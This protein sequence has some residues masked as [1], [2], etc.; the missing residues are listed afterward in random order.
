MQHIAWRYLVTNQARP[1]A[2][3]SF[4]SF[5]LGLC[6][7][8]YVCLY[9]CLYLCLYLGLCLCLYLCYSNAPNS[10]A[11]RYLVTNQALYTFIC[12]NHFQTPI[13]LSLCIC[14]PIHLYLC[15]SVNMHPCTLT[16]VYA[17]LYPNIRI[18]TP[19]LPSLFVCLQLPNFNLYTSA[20]LL[21][22]HITYMSTHSINL[23][24]WV[25]YS[26]FGSL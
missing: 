21:L 12:T 22:A 8:L 11:W 18:C 4:I 3:S 10:S 15:T 23:T 14:I 1:K 13:Y 26:F 25:A 19:P 6:L 17:P 9:S 16:Y 2:L 7:C 20:F 24:N 5:Y